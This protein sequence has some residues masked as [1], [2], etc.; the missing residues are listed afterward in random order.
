MKIRYMQP[1][2]HGVTTLIYVGD[3]NAVERAVASPTP[4]QLGIGVVA[5]L[6]ALQSQG[7]TR[8]VAMGVAGVI[9]YRALK[10][11]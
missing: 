11:R 9:G 6:V 5:A 1:V 10:S 4:A 7:V 3:D 2:D 8:L